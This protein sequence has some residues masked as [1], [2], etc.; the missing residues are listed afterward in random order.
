MSAALQRVQERKQKLEE[1]LKLVEKQVYELESAYLTEHAQ[2]GS[3]LKGF[4]SFLM[5]SKSGSN[6]KRSRTFKPEERLFSLSS[7]TGQIDA[8]DA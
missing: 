6:Q 3:V 2:C 5:S 8:P 7:V 4:D 1:E